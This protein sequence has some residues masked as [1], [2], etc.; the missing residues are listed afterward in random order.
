MGLHERQGVAAAHLAATGGL[1]VSL[2]ALPVSSN[3]LLDKIPRKCLFSFGV[4]EGENRSALYTLANPTGRA[5]KQM[6]YLQKWCIAEGCLTKMAGFDESLSA[7]A[8]RDD[9]RFVAVG[10]MFGGSVSIYIA[11]SLQ[12]SSC[13]N[14]H[15]YFC[16]INLCAPS[17]LPNCCNFLNLKYP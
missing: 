17:S 14:H 4:I 3:G 12:V 8:V 15:Y 7:L 1:A 11:F 6:A 5:G 10:T 13:T 16:I 2:Q 9:G